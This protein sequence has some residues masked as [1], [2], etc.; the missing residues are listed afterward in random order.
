MKHSIR[1][2]AAHS[3]IEPLL[4]LK[5]R[6]LHATLQSNAYAFSI[7]DEQAFKSIPGTGVIITVAGAGGLENKTQTELPTAGN[8]SQF[9]QSGAK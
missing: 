3:L 5:P 8:Y 4:S 2:H 1:M 7:D 6:H 9:C